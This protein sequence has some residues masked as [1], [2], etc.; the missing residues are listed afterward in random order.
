M[1]DFRSA[2]VTL[3]ALGCQ[4]RLPERSP[5][6]KATMPLRSKIS[7]RSRPS[8]PNKTIYRCSQD[9]LTDSV[10]R[11]N[12]QFHATRAREEKQAYTVAAIGEELLPLTSIARREKHRPRNHHDDLRRRNDNRGPAL[13]QQ[14][15]GEGRRVRRLGAE[16]L[17][18]RE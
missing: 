14:S 3:N 8:R 16:P 10:F 2:I 5:P 9:G 15:R 17:G 12:R 1:L 13:P 6:A 18:D 7:T 11:S 4:N